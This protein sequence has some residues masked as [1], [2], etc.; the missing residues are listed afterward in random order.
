MAAFAAKVAT[1]RKD[2]EP[3]PRP[4]NDRILHNPSNTHEKPSFLTATRGP[5]MEN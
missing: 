5:Q 3:K 2:R 1:L 4:V